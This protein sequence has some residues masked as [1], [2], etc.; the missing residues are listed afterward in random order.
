M[1]EVISGQECAEVC[2]PMRWMK[3]EENTRKGKET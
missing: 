1:R 2:S 3:T